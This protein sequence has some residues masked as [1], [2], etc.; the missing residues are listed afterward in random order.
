VF[1][2]ALDDA[3]SSEKQR[4]PEPAPVFDVVIDEEGRHR[5]RFDI[6]HSAQPARVRRL[7]LRV[8]RVV[9]RVA[10]QDEADRHE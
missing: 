9:H 2:A 5:I 4:V 1:R 7:R 6:L 10:A 8:D 3:S